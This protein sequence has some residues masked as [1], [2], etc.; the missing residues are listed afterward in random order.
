[1]VGWVVQGRWLD[2][3][4]KL[5]GKPTSDNT[6]TTVYAKLHVRVCSLLIGSVILK[7]AANNIK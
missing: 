5:I 6:D 3:W 4:S 1:M 7:P 2:G